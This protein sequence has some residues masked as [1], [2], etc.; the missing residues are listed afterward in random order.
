MLPGLNCV[1][2]FRPNLPSQSSSQ[3]VLHT[4]PLCPDSDLVASRFHSTHRRN[5]KVAQKR[6]V[7]IER[8][9]KLE[10]L[11]AFYRLHLQTRR[12]QG[13]PIQPWRL[14]DMLGSALIVKGLGFVL[15]A[16]KDG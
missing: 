15:L 11:E 8:G 10:H 4:L 14:F 16:Y 5:I 13:I 6:G 9:E 12:R 2:S 3:H 7:H 1:A